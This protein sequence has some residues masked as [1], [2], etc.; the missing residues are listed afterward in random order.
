MH[1]ANNIWSGVW[2]IGLV[3]RIF[4]VPVPVPVSYGGGSVHH[5]EI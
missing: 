2:K 1:C 4:A 3:G 5:D